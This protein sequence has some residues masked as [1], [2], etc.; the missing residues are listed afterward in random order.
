V[1][2]DGTSQD[3]GANLAKLRLDQLPIGKSAD[4]IGVSAGWVWQRVGALALDLSA[5]DPFESMAAAGATA[6][7]PCDDVCGEERHRACQQKQSGTQHN[8]DGGDG[9]RQG[10][11]A[12]RVRHV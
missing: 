8:A 11:D 2:Y 12:C 1:N 4:F 7:Q 9:F 10:Q 5:G 3:G 6:L